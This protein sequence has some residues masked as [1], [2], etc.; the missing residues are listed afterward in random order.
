M[1]MKGQIKIELKAIIPCLMGKKKK[2]E[3]QRETIE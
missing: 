3:F 1:K 2:K